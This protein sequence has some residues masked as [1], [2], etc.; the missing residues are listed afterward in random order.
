MNIGDFVSRLNIPLGVTKR[1]DCPACA[2]SNT[3]SVT[4]T[5]EGTKWYCFSSSCG[6]RGIID[7]DLSADQVREYL[8]GR[9]DNKA[10]FSVPE[11][12]VAGGN[13]RDT[14]KYL[15]SYNLLPLINKRIDVRYD[16]KKDRHVFIGRI[17]TEVTGAYGRANKNGK[18]KWYNYFGA[19]TPYIVPA[20]R[21]IGEAPSY[22]IGILV[23]DPPS[24][25]AV[26][27]AYD[28][29][30]LTGTN[31]K[32]KY[33]P[34][35]AKYKQLVIC[36]DKDA[37]KKS[38]DMQRKLCYYSDTKVALLERDLKYLSQEEILDVV[39]L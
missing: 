11:Y 17:G 3:F 30:A 22:E 29:V 12:W 9:K 19:D 8:R 20:S 39:G 21:K 25:A 38:L 6:V 15:K 24:A 14:A 1:F 26:S 27:F 37:S 35:L 7:S 5:V 32:D 36:L 2:K 34:V 33:I 31:L 18:P 23:E 28:G 4:K 13:N 10:Q 16:P